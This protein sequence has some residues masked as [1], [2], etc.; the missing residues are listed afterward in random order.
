VTASEIITI[1]MKKTGAFICYPFGDDVTIIKVKSKTS[2]ARIFVQIFEL[3]GEPF[4]TFN[5]DRMT[6]EF[7]R[8]IYPDTVTRGWHCPPVMHPYFNTVQLNRNVPD[9]E[10]VNMISH[11]YNVVVAKLPKYAQKELNN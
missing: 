7:Y 2:Q 3:N 8:N 4:A 1:C 10:I 5:C 11:S 9:E 6:G